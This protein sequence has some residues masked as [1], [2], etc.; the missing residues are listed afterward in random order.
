[1]MVQNDLHSAETLLKILN[2]DMLSGG[3]R[4]EG[5]LPGSSQL[6][7]PKISVSPVISGEATQVPQ[8]QSSQGT[9]LSGTQGRMYIVYLCSLAQHCT[10]ELAVSPP[11]EHP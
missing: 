5:I 9:E 2:A 8:L 10:G 6:E 11:Y 4:K 7:E 1:M 3:H